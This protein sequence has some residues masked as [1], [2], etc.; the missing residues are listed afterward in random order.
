MKEISFRSFLVVGLTLF[1]M[2]FGAGNFIFPPFLGNLAGEQTP[3][4]II[5]FCLT[6]VLFPILGIAAVAKSNG[7]HNLAQ[8]ISPKF[9]LIFSIFLL[10]I[11]GPFFAIPRAANMPFELA[12]KPFLSQ[13]LQ[14]SFIPLFL[15]SISYFIVNW[16][17]SR[18]P[19]KMIS[20][21]GKILTPILLI[22]ILVLF[23]VSIID[24]L[25][26]S[27]FL[28]AKGSYAAHPIT[29]GILEGYQ[30]MDAL[31]SLSFGLV[32]LLT[33][34]RIGIKD[35]EKIVSATIKAGLLAGLILMI[36]Y[37]MLSY[38]GASAGAAV[39][40][41]E[42]APTN[43]AEIL[44]I[45]TEYWFGKY[46][47]IIFGLAM[48]LAC[49]TTTVGLTCAI[50]E[51]FITIT[52]IKYKHWIIIWSVISSLMA[53]VGL[54]AIINYAVPF[55]GIIYPLALSLIV[56]S[57]LNNKLNEDKF[58]YSLVIYVVLVISLI[59]TFDR[60]FNIA[61]P[62][63]VD[64]CRL[65]PLYDQSLEWMIPGIICLLVGMIKIKSGKK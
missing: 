44:A 7:L 63:L 23:A 57:L 32:I 15:Y 22:L 48:F 61:I 40:L 10:L 34:K 9:A 64:L 16:A 37:M 27:S 65:L 59:G 62:G 14:A 1:S 11:I 12:I 52:K 43:G 28:Q 51:Y 47:I 13:G 2:F 20:T 29:T 50:S 35:N 56:L 17:L 46:G 31:A 30:T 54:T 42:Q 53:N 41:F 36:I 8:R 60:S 24:P 33:F 49:L 26:S 4:A 45:A 6:A 5:A 38:I 39:G 55:L 18:N 58:T 19:T 21:L 25:H 3:I